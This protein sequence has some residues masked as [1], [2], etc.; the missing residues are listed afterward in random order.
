[1]GFVDYIQTASGQKIG[2]S[3]R[4][5]RMKQPVVNI[6][7]GDFDEEEREALDYYPGRYASTRENVFWIN[8]KK[9][10]ESDFV[11]TVPEPDE[12][13]SSDGRGRL[14]EYAQDSEQLKQE[15]QEYAGVIFNKS[16]FSHM[17]FQNPGSLQINFLVKSDEAFSG[18]LEP[19][20]VLAEEA[21]AL[22][23]DSFRKK[24][25]YLFLNQ[26]AAADRADERRIS[27]YLT[28]CETDSMMHMENDKGKLRLA[29]I[30]SNLY[31][32]GSLG[33]DYRRERCL[34]AG[35][36]C[37]M[38][39]ALTEGD[40]K[41][42]Y[43]DDAFG[44]AVA[45]IAMM[46]HQEP[47]M[48]SSLGYMSFESRES[49]AKLAVYRAVFEEMMNVRGE[50]Q[51]DEFPDK[52][53]EDLNMTEADWKMAAAKTKRG[54]TLT[55]L[56]WRSI[57]RKRVNETELIGKPNGTCIERLYGRN[58]DLYLELNNDGEKCQQEANR[59]I[60]EFERNLQAVVSRE[61][62]SPYE[63]IRILEWAEK[64]LVQQETQ[65]RRN[66]EGCRNKLNEWERKRCDNLS[67]RRMP[68]TRE[69]ETLYKQAGQYIS[70]KQ[71]MMDAQNRGKELSCMQENLRAL[72][73]HFERYQKLIGNACRDLEEKIREIES[74]TTK[75]K[76]LQIVNSAAFY[77]HLTGDILKQS[78]RYR[79]LCEKIREMALK[80]V[81]AETAEN[82]VYEKVRRFCE[83][84]EQDEQGVL[85][86][87]RFRGV[88]TEEFFRRMK[89]YKQENGNELRDSSA[90]AD[91]LVQKIDQCKYYMF[92]SIF[93]LSRI[94][95]QM[96]F[97]LDSDS[98]FAK[99]DGG[100]G[101]AAALI[102]DNKLKFF[103]ERGCERLDV[104][105]LAGNIRKE[106]LVQFKSYQEAYS[107]AA[108]GGGK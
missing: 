67:R 6:L 44:K 40:I 1:M 86:Q 56:D 39:N 106:E 59:W 77:S 103:G 5:L 104:L 82:D 27:N 35:M 10:R 9:Q 54:I 101:L 74:A 72:R 102:W 76:E 87:I 99:A 24:D 16:A 26:Q 58:L 83:Q 79:E 62:L 25:A 47:G 69:S 3:E 97:L 94:Y 53:R 15:L 90:I 29:Y 107:R 38:K 7:L 55:E 22:Y 11:L 18:L 95:E 98:Q 61:R 36:L 92:K 4:T 2:S 30:L 12:K 49:L 105:F 32:S 14:K 96:C 45:G 8:V 42:V 88:F 64:E 48:F 23:Y 51:A 73:G 20:S 34:A 80:R 28:L 78:M 43:S 52:F 84:D 75:V 66:A 81:N 89:G 33:P 50:M 57:A 19:L 17:A 65:C 31:S 68:V 60:E 93:E 85:N 13:Y 100:K 37:L 70:L 108:E 71:K 46:N 91:Y 41:N 63:L 21:F